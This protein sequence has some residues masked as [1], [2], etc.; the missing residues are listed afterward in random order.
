MWKIAVI[1]I[2]YDKH[3]LLGPALDK[4]KPSTTR[5]KK[6]FFLHLFYLF[7]QLTFFLASYVERAWKVHENVFRD[8]QSQKLI[9][10][11]DAKKKVNWQNN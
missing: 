5:P 7:C 1:F 8:I 4:N 6:C 9:S 10:R 3:P 11:Y 2:R